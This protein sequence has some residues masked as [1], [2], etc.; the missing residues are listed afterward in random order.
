MK[1]IA[2]ENLGGYHGLISKKIEYEYVK[3]PVRMSGMTYIFQN[4]T[5]PPKN[6]LNLF[7]FQVQKYFSIRDILVASFQ[8]WK[9]GILRLV[10]MNR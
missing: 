4:Q 3:K 5:S 2:R 1:C 7:K 8:K 6:F 10:M 9:G